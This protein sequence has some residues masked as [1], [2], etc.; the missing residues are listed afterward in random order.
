V[1][2]YDTSCLRVAT[3]STKKP[4]VEKAK[5]SYDLAQEAESK[6]F[7]DR[8]N[9]R[10]AECQ[11]QGGTYMLG[12]KNAC[13]ENGYLSNEV[14]AQV[15]GCLNVPCNEWGSCLGRLNDGAVCVTN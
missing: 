1:I 3:C 11:T 7:V 5:E 6:S 14:L 12:R 4:C 2:E 13:D 9:K 8:C 10:F 15:E